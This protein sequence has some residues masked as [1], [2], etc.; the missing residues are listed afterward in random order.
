MSNNDSLWLVV[1][2]GALIGFLA[3]NPEKEVSEKEVK[4]ELENTEVP[5]GP[6]HEFLEEIKTLFQNGHHRQ[7]VLD[8][9]QLMYKVIRDKSGIHNMD[10][11]QLINNAFG[12][13]GCLRFDTHSDHAHLETH[14]GYYYLCKGASMAFRNPAAHAPIKHKPQEAALQ[15]QLMA[16]LIDN[17]Q[18][19]TVPVT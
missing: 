2:I 6:Y 15:I 18:Y 10:G 8:T 13:N 19:K 16:Y 5:Q 4:E 11:D 3:S 7:A 17:I 9:S 12:K 1:G 14:E